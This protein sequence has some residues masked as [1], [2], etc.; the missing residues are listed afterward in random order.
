MLKTHYKYLGG[1]WV[2]MIPN[3]DNN[4]SIWGISYRKVCNCKKQ[5]CLICFCLF[6][7]YLKEIEWLLEE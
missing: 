5:P 1:I 6:T 7:L 3:D 2:K 4:V